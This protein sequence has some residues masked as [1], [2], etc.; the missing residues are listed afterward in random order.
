[1]NNDDEEYEGLEILY[2]KRRS[3]GN[4]GLPENLKPVGRNDIKMSD[5]P[6]VAEKS[7]KPSLT[8]VSK[9]LSKIKTGALK[10][11][12]AVKKAVSTK[13]RAFRQGKIEIGKKMLQQNQAVAERTSQALVALDYVPTVIMSDEQKEGVRK[14]VTEGLEGIANF[15]PLGHFLAETKGKSLKEV[16]KVK[17]LPDVETER[18]KRPMLEYGDWNDYG[19]NRLPG[20]KRQKTIPKKKKVRA[21]MPEMPSVEVF[22]N[23]GEI[24]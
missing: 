6:K 10:K 23:M 20:G 9:E 21:I 14:H 2:R 22:P 19:I 11:K 15:H 16:S 17:L 12:G 5:I 4:N 18:D 3:L 24:D 7:S 1:M 8:K 13:E